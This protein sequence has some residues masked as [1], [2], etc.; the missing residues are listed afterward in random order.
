MI[1]DDA[2][3]RDETDLFRRVHPNHVVPDL[4]GD[5][6]R[7]RPS[8]AAFKDVEMS[9]NLADTLAEEGLDPSFAV[10]EHPH[11]FL[12]AITAGD[13][14]T[15]PALAIVRSPTDRDPTH[16]DVLGEKRKSW[17]S[18]MA[19]LA[20]WEIERDHPDDPRTTGAPAAA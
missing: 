15:D 6:P 7:L 11:H 3:I 17:R 2:S 1:G 5:Y 16:G 8:S 9:V 14:R 12:A 19:Q 4:N 20:R 10:R 18:R 13:A